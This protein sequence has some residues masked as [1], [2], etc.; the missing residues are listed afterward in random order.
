M[1][2]KRIQ[3]PSTSFAKPPPFSGPSPAP[4]LVQHKAPQRYSSGTRCG[5]SGRRGGRKASR[6]HRERRSPPCCRGR[7]FRPVMR[8]TAA[9]VVEE[10]SHEQKIQLVVALRVPHP[11]QKIYPSPIEKLLFDSTVMF[12]ANT[13]CTPFAAIILTFTVLTITIHITNDNHSQH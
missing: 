7:E 13:K 2:L 3:G 4:G 10:V 6:A 8:A 11:L 5:T 9:K 12:Y 1:E